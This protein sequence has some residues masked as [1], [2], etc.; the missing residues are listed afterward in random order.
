MFS[1]ER[2]L[3]NILVDVNDAKTT[4]KRENLKEGRDEKSLTKA[5]EH[6]ALII[7]RTEGHLFTAEG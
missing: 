4:E 1:R 2:A 5:W 7:S 3:V 6:F